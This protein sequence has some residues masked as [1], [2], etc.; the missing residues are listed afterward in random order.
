MELPKIVRKQIK[1]V[2]EYMRLKSLGKY[3]FKF[4]DETWIFRYGS[5]TSSEWILEGDERTYSVATTNSGQRYIILHCGGRDGW[6]PG[7]SLMFQSQSNDGDYHGEMDGGV[8]ESWYRRQLAP[9]IEADT[10]IILD[11]AIYHTRKGKVSIM[12]A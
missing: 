10:I 7:A 1:F 5:F 12:L 11:N 6:V 8:F 2:R 3:D 9:N 4:L